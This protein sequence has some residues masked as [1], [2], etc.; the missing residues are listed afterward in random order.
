MG[1]LRALKQSELYKQVPEPSQSII[2]EP[3]QLLTELS[4]GVEPTTSRASPLM[5]QALG[6]CKNTYL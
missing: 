3:L 1:Q 2:S 4:I 6:I 5:Q